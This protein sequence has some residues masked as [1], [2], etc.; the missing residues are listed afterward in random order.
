[1]GRKRILK[2]KNLLEAIEGS[3]GVVSVIA[4]KLNVAWDTAN[5]A[6]K[7]SEKASQ[8][9]MNECERVLDFAENKIFESIKAGNTNNAKWYLTKKGKARGYG[10]EIQLENIYAEDNEIKIIVDN[11]N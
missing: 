9:Y 6:I 1:M 11:G 8:A 4:K 5:D 10:D 2:E 3:N 7:R